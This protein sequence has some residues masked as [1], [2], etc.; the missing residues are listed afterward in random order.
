MHASANATAVESHEK[1]AMKSGFSRPLE[2]VVQ[3]RRREMMPLRFRD[4]LLRASAAKR[5]QRDTHTYTPLQAPLTLITF[6]KNFFRGVVS[7]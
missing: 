4:H 1:I 3:A 6:C 7:D 2:R 5:L